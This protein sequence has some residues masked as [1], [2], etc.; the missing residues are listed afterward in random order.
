MREFTF[1]CNID[2]QDYSLGL[3]AFLRYHRDIHVLHEMKRV[4]ANIESNG[5]VLSHDD[6]NLLN[7]E[8]ALEV[9]VAIRKSCGSDGIRALFKTQLKESEQRW[10]DM[11]AASEG[12][13][14]R[15][16]I[17]DITI[18]GIPFEEFAKNMLEQTPFL[19]NYPA[20]HPDH[21]FI[22]KENGKL[23]GV[24][25]FGMYGGPSEMC[26]TPVSD[27]SVPIERDES[28]PFAFGAVATLPD[29]TN[30]N[31]PAFMQFKPIENGLIVKAGCCFPATVPNEMLEGHKLHLAI[32]FLEFT[33]TIAAAH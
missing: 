9:S 18:T 26:L 33:R 16:C 1:E 19:Q 28:Y 23:Q 14:L 2:G 13:P 25:T 32:E 22:S 17:A 20:V 10:R 8:Q 15:P 7:A 29:G 30:S 6:I 21:F 3:L 31:A 24:E 5:K 4:G 12:L 11:N 27:L